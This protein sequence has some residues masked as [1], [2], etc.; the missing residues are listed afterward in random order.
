MVLHVGEGFQRA[1]RNK[2][3]YLET[4][5]FASTLPFSKNSVQLWGT[6]GGNSQLWVTFGA[7]IF[8]K[9][10][11]GKFSKNIWWENFKRTFG[12]DMLAGTFWR[13]S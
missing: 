8:K 9:T 10:F 2:N 4:N 3:L 11:G 6:F 7:N 1:L 13:E 5:E 12:R